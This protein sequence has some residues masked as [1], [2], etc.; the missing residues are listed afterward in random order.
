MPARSRVLVGLLS[1]A[2]LAAPA[3]SQAAPG[4]SGANQL[5]DS[6]HE[7]FWP[8]VAVA[9]DGT[10]GTIWRQ[11]DGANDREYVAV[12]SPQSR[13]WSDAQPLSPAGVDVPDSSEALASD[14]D[15]NIT[16]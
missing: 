16:A 2:A 15:G 4:W 5:S 9:P 14:D 12:Y 8:K 6:V 13:T 3:A 10:V 11:S 1:I 7:A